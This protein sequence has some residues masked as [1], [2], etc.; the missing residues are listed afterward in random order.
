MKIINASLIS[1]EDGFWLE[2]S[3]QSM[4]L[5]ELQWLL[6]TDNDAVYYEKQMINIEYMEL[7]KKYKSIEY[8]IEISKMLKWATIESCWS[9]WGWDQNGS[10]FTEYFDN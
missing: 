5:C 7:Q 4:Q 6:V 10:F 2:T 3:M 9:H 1:K 8:T